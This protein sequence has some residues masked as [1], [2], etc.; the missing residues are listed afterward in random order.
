AGDVFVADTVNGR[1]LELPAGSGTQQTL[2]LSGL[3]SPY[4]LA[5]DQ[6]GD[7]FVAD[8]GTGQVLELPAGGGAQQTLPFSGLSEPFGLAV[9]QA[10]D[11]FVGD[12]GNTRVVELPAVTSTLL[13]TSLSGGG[14]SGTSISV[15]AGIGVSDQGSL[16]GPHA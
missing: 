8:D 13:D 6:A 1:V 4:G 3:E 10:G 11:L 9:D 5:V 7:V 14:R 16:S 12:W 2:P 15:P